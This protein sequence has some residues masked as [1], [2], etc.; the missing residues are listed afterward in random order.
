MTKEMDYK[1]GSELPIDTTQVVKRQLPATILPCG[2]IS[3]V[4][5]VHDYFNVIE[6]GQSVVEVWEVKSFK[7]SC[8]GNNTKISYKF[9]VTSGKSPTYE[10]GSEV[11]FTHDQN[12]KKLFFGTLVNYVDTKAMDKLIPLYGKSGYS[13]CYK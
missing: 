10:I 6:N 13:Y 8:D 9:V 12:F 2:R 7:D 5:G 11:Y 3:L 4:T 1:L